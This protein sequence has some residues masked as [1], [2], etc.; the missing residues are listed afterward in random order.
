MP[1]LRDGWRGFRT[2]CHCRGAN[3]TIRPPPSSGIAGGGGL[4]G[5]CELS[6]FFHR[7]DRCCRV[8]MFVSM[9][10]PEI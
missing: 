7:G 8:R 10:S 2:R 3:V 1:G 9:R 5:E 4:I 6:E